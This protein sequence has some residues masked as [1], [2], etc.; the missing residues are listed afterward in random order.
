MKLKDDYDWKQYHNHYSKQHAK[1]SKTYTQ[2]LTKNNF[3][4]INGVIKLNDDCFPLHDNHKLLY[5]TVYG[6]HPKSVLEIGCGWG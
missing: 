4:L 3:Q 5:E 6:L 1:I 2:V